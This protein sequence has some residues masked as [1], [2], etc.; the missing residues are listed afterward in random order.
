M[1]EC[2]IGVS[3][4]EHTKEYEYQYCVAETFADIVLVCLFN[5]ILLSNELVCRRCGDG[6]TTPFLWEGYP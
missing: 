6:P 4:W 1:V 5:S 3:C 2:G